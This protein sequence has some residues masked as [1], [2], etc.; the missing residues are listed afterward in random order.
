[1]KLSRQVQDVGEIAESAV[2][3]LKLQTESKKLSIELDLP[4]IPVV[5]NIDR[6]RIAQVLRNLLI[7]A[8]HFTPEKGTIN[9]SVQH[10]DSYI[11]VAVM[12]TGIGIPADQIPY[13]FERFYRV[14][15]SRAGATGGTGLGL[16]I[17]SKLVEAHGGNIRVESEPGKGSRFIFTLPAYFK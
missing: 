12:D 2:K 15:K 17:A 1:M 8:I 13:I 7:N 14:D 11:E 10:K 4:D 16:T 3:A 5:A 6:E 9:V